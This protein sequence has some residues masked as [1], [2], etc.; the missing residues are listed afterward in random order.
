MSDIFREVDEEVRSDQFSKLWKRFAPVVYLTAGLI[1]VGTAGYRGYEYW[2]TKQSQAA[3]TEFLE[4]VKLSDAGNYAE[5]QA[6][7]VSMEGAIGGYPMMAKMRVGTELALEG[8]SDEAIKAFEAVAAD[9]STPT[10]YKGLANIRAAY[11]LLDSGDLAA[12]KKH[13]EVLA[14]AGNTWRFSALEILGAAEYKAG[15]LEAARTRF[16]EIVNDAA[17]PSDISGRAQIYLE[18]ITS[19]LGKDEKGTE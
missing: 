7:F 10:I 5:A 8:K 19:A 1:V 13:T 17:A 14:V 12:V 16:S 4:A 11:L 3:G 9:S 18:L 15:N 2:Q 6:A